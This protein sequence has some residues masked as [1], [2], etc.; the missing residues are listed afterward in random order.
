[1]SVMLLHDKYCNFLTKYSIESF[2]SLGV[3][4]GKRIQFSETWTDTVYIVCREL[5]HDD[6]L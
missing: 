1:M 2:N 6:S 3:I 4:C 5:I